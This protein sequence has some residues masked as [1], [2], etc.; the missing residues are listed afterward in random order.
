MSIV[1]KSVP[2]PNWVD[3]GAESDFPL[4]EIVARL[5]MDRAVAVMRT[6]VGLICCL[7]E[8]AH[9]PVPLSDFGEI[10]GMTLV[11]HAHG[12]A[13]DL[14]ECG[15]PLCFPAT[16]GLQVFRHR[17]RVGRVEILAI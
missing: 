1:D 12:A 5:V 13:Y 7:D 9:Q 2:Q 8:C 3:V 11:C 4:N 14:G 17:I 10:R 6:P 15:K 16:E